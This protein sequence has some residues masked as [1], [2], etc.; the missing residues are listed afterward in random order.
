MF[1]GLP[2]TLTIFDVAG[3][4]AYSG[5]ENIVEGVSSEEDIADDSHTF[6]NQGIS[7]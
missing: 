2:K 1:E 3:V 4:V 6:A 5:V 7:P